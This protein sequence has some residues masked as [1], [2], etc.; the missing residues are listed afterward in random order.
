MRALSITNVTDVLV[1]LCMP[2]PVSCSVS[3]E[4]APALGLPAGLNWQETDGERSQGIYSGSPSTP[5]PDPSRSLDIARPQFSYVCMAGGINQIT[6]EV[7][8]TCCPIFLLLRSSERIV[9]ICQVKEVWIL[10]W[11]FLK[12][13][14]MPSLRKG[15]KWQDKEVP[16]LSLSLF[17]LFTV[18]WFLFVI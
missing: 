12:V 2:L 9:H 13:V 18:D 8:F 5:S 1:I 15:S 3:P 10:N 17:T 14:R 4:G 16:D 11:S 6:S 7:V